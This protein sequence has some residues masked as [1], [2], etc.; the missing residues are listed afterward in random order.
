MV[1]IGLFGDDC[2]NVGCIVKVDDDCIDDGDGGSSDGEE[3]EDDYI[4][5]I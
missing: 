1:E 4:G 5:A 3:G 2:L